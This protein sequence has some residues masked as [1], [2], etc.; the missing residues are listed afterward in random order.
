MKLRILPFLFLALTMT[1]C[2]SDSSDGTGSS[3]SANTNS[4]FANAN[5]AT[6]RLEFPKLKDA[7][8]NVVIVHYSG[9]E[10]NYSVEYDINKK[11]SRWSC[12]EIYASNRETHTQRYYSDSNQY[13]QDPLLNA[14]YRWGTDPFYRSGYDH[15]HLCPSADRLN[16]YNANYQTF[17]LTNMLAQEHTFNAGVWA[18]ME[19]WVRNQITITSKDTLYVVKGGTIDN[20]SQYT[21]MDRTGGKLIIPKYYFMAVLMRNS[22]GYKAMGFWIEH[23]ANS[24]KNLTPYV[25]NIDKLESLTGIDFFCNLPDDIENHIESLPVENVKKAWGFK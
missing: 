24:A 3:E 16:S 10:V 12:Y 6:H 11:L 7:S 9:G 14:Q 22:S 21:T 4:N 13:P 2:G 15:G 1:A 19:T 23:K 25:V 8:A 20:A 18:N 5:P 17:F